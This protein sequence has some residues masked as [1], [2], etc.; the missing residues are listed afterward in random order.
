VLLLLGSSRDHLP[1]PDGF[2]FKDSKQG[3]LTIAR[4]VAALAE[5]IVVPDGG[6][7][8]GTSDLPK[9]T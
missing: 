1:F 8:S 4:E 6:N 2:S 3:D 9:V 7:D 5:P